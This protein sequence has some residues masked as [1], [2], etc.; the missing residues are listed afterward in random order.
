MNVTSTGKITV[1]VEHQQNWVTFRISD[2][3]PGI[4]AEELPH[5]FERFWRGKTTDY[6][7]TGLGLAISKGIVEA[8]GGRIWVESEMGVGSTFSF[9]L[10]VKTQMG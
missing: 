1:R 2:T 3:G 8:H 4:K 7:G 9:S 10:P 6:K 5:L